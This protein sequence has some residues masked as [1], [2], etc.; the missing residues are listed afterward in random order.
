MGQYYKPIN[1]EKKEF[2]R[3]YEYDNGAKLMEHSYIGNNFIAAVE[4]LLSPDGHWH[5]TP[6]V[7]AGDYM[8]DGLFLDKLPHEQVRQLFNEEEKT[9]YA[10]A[11]HHFKE[12][13]GEHAFNP[14]LIFI[15]NHSKNEYVD[16]SKLIAHFQKDNLTIN[17]L[18]LLTCSGNGRG[19]GD[20]SGVDE[21]MVGEWA[22]DTISMEFEKPENYQERIVDFLEER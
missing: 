17:P 9:L 2:L 21:S 18:P 16:R 1:L 19:G 10:Y 6:F 20:Y 8:D 11:R 3:S 5:K 7:W 4:F 12:Y 15:V 14:D 13:K 22:G